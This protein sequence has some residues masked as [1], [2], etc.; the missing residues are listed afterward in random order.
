MNKQASMEEVTPLV[1]ET[2]G[3]SMCVGICVRFFKVL[4]PLLLIGRQRR[5]LGEHN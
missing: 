3:V 2:S 5:K 1:K 4:F